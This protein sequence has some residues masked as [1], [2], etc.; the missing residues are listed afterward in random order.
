MKSGPIRSGWKLA[1]V[2]SVSILLIMASQDTWDGY[3]LTPATYGYI[4]EDK[5][6]LL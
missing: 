2:P 1:P 6:H 3:E 5:E 4:Q